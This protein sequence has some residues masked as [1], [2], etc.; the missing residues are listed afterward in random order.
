MPPSALEPVVMQEEANERPGAAVSFPY[1]AGL[2]ARFR[3]AFPRARWRDDRRIWLVPGK[4]AGRRLHRWLERELSGVLAHADQRGRTL[5][6]SSRSSAPIWRPQTTCSSERLI[7][8]RSWRRCALS[9]GPG[10]MVIKGFGAFRSAPSTNCGS[11]GPRSRPRLS[12]M[13]PKPGSAG[14]KKPGHRPNSHRTTPSRT[15]VA[16]CVIRFRQMRCR[17]WID[18]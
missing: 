1:D 16:G 7:R 9:P 12:A 17:R 10:G 6:P 8:R 18:R 11:A 5:L 4:L 14:L 3:T 2:V 15:S 13:N